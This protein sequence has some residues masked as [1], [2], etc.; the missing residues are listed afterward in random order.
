MLLV[1]KTEPLASYRNTNMAV[2]RTYWVGVTL[3][4]PNAGF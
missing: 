4:P 1:M 3:L 2:V